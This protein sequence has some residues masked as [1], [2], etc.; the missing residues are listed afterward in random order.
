MYHLFFVNFKFLLPRYFVGLNIL[1]GSFFFYG[2]LALMGVTPHPLPEEYLKTILISFLPIYSFFFYTKKGLITRENLNIFIVI[3]FIFAFLKY[4]GIVY[5]KSLL[6]ISGEVDFTNNA[7]YLFLPL[8]ATGVFFNKKIFQYVTLCICLI[9]AIESSKRGVMFTCFGCLFWFLY[10]SLRGTNMKTKLGV[11]LFFAA[12]IFVGY[13]TFERHILESYAFQSKMQ[14]LMDGDGN[15]RG[16][17]YT[18]FLNYFWNETNAFQFVFG[19]GANATLSIST[20][21]AHNDWIEIAVNQGLL[22]VG[23]YILYFLIFFR[24]CCNQTYNS[25]I[26]L[27]LQLIFLICF[28]KT[29]FSMSYGDM[30]TSTCFVLGYCLAQGNKNER[31]LKSV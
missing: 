3:F 21:Y 4:Y 22:G 14:D 8:M 20:H 15:G 29:F 7:E 18:T 2:M 31:F 26:K 27:A 17:L 28:V 5:S 25:K 13:V 11:V 30:T 24:E 19:S 10:N 6:S 12:L 9:I 1:L 23:L 16:T